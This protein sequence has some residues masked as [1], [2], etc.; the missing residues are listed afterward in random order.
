MRY[1]YSKYLF[2][3]LC[4]ACFDKII[5]YVLTLKRPT[6]TVPIFSST[7]VFIAISI[8]HPSS[9]VYNYSGNADTFSQ[10]G[11]R[12]CEM[13]TTITLSRYVCGTSIMLKR[14]SVSITTL[15]RGIRL[16]GRKNKSVLCTR[17]G[18]SDVRTL[19]HS[20]GPLKN[21]K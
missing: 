16:M 12:K 5:P 7:I 21:I 17:Y 14:Y 19:N 18:F 9:N 10:Y 3:C 4:F 8:V 20:R 11:E 6:K 13:W 2:Q 15:H 1:W